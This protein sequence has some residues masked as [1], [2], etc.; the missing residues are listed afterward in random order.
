MEESRIF[1]QSLGFKLRALD[2]SGTG[3]TRVAIT[4]LRNQYHVVCFKYNHPNLSC[5]GYALM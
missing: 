5:F 4:S 1:Q 3:I 2:V